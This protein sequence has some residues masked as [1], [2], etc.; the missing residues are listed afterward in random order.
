MG[1]NKRLFPGAGGYQTVSPFQNNIAAGGYNSSTSYP[2][3]YGATNAELNANLTGNII[4][5]TPCVVADIY[6][7]G[8]NG[9]SRSN[10][11]IIMTMAGPTTTNGLTSAGR[12]QSNYHYT[13]VLKWWGSND[14]SS[15]TELASHSH[16]GSGV[17]ISCQVLSS[18]YTASTWLYYKVD[19]TAGNRGTYGGFSY[20]APS[21]VT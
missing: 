7:F 12:A 17:A 18:S 11:Q 9:S 16:T 15:W 3:G 1:L 8:N 13:G 19:I 6:N 14:G 2:T 10:N 21:V 5:T 4:W 20:L